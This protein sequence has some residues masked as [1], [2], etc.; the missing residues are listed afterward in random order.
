MT[1]FV[2]INRLT[3]YEYNLLMKGVMLKKLDEKAE[4]H[5]RAWLSR[6]VNAEKRVGKDKTEYVF[7]KFSDFF[8]Y[9]KE[10]NNLFGD[11]D[12]FSEFKKLVL[13]ANKG[14]C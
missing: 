10:Y 5:E 13:E 4:R 3:L 2:L 9:D 1:D 12:N 11:A 8:N 6:V 14:V 7:K